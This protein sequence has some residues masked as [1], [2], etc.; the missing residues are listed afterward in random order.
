MANFGPYQFGQVRIA[1]FPGY[2]NL[3]KGSPN[4]IPFSETLGF[5]GDFRDPA[6]LDFL[7]LTTAHEMAHQYWG[8][9]LTPAGVPRGC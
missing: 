5:T 7:P 1:E 4:T 2:M 9:Q 8:S 3:A 6:T